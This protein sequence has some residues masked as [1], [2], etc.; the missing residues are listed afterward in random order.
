MNCSIA[1]VVLE[2]YDPIIHEWIRLPKG[3][4]AQC[5]V[6]DQAFL[7]IFR[8]GRQIIVAF[9]QFED[10]FDLEEVLPGLDFPAR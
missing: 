2:P 8:D 9:P 10:Y 7:V 1:G 3:W 5:F 6:V 4:E